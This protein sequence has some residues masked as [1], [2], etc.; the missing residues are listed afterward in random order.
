M[1]DYLFKN[2]IGLIPIYLNYLNCL[3]ISNYLNHYI[4][5]HYPKESIIKYF[6]RIIVRKFLQ[7]Y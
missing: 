1:L 5:Y 3:F 7:K 6:F 4:K 2:L